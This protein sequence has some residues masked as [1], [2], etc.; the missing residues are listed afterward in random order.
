VCVCAR[1]R[2]RAVQG[3]QELGSCLLRTQDFITAT[4]YYIVLYHFNNS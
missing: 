3:K 2:A 1:A 4:H